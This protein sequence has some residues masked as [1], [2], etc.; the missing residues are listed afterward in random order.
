MGAIFRPDGVKMAISRINYVKDNSLSFPNIGR[1]L[2]FDDGKALKNGDK[3]GTFWD[4]NVTF[5]TTVTKVEP[6][7]GRFVA[8][9]ICPE[10]GTRCWNRFWDCTVLPLFL[11]GQKP[12]KKGP[13]LAI[14]QKSPHY[15]VIN[16]VIGWGKNFFT[17]FGDTSKPIPNFY[18][19]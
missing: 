2:K 10:V 13:F 16:D 18:R 11:G 8:T 15:D 7:A 4:Q 3:V 14:F 6:L 9:K 19:G 5:G 12:P 1:N 17:Y